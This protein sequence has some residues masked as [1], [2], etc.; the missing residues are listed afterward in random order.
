MTFPVSQSKLIGFKKGGKSSRKQKKK[1]PNKKKIRVSESE[2]KLRRWKKKYTLATPRLGNS[3]GKLIRA[4]E[5]H[6]EDEAPDESVTLNHWKE[7]FEKNFSL[8]KTRVLCSPQAFFAHSESRKLLKKLQEK[9]GDNRLRLEIMKLR[10][11]YDYDLEKKIFADPDEAWKLHEEIKETQEIIENLV[12]Q[13]R[14]DDYQLRLRELNRRLFCETLKL[15]YEATAPCAVRVYIPGLLK[16]E[17]CLSEEEKEENF[18][19]LFNEIMYE[20][21]ETSLNDT[22][23]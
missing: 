6:P 19:E 12:S 8:W 9:P 17:E 22:F 23:Q 10:R 20:F 16:S 14:L 7:Q 5:S 13:K 18:D 21:H 11:D 4:A 2:K 1:M 15:G 3:L